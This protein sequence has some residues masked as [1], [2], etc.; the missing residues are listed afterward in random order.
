MQEI[1]L[2]T[3]EVYSPIFDIDPRGKVETSEGS[4]ETRV[5]LFENDRPI[6]EKVLV[7][8]YFADSYNEPI[9]PSPRANVLSIQPSVVE[10]Q[11]DV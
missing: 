2:E 1:L 5:R 8:C 9:R 7:V 3:L 4:F 11:R 10:S 6:C